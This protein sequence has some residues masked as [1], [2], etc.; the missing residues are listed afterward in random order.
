LILIGVLDA[1]EIEYGTPHRGDSV[2]MLELLE[3]YRFVSTFPTWP[4]GLSATSR[5][6]SAAALSFLP[7]LW[8]QFISP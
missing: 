1:L 8:S 5:A 2:R 4:F 3:L 7:Q 6:I